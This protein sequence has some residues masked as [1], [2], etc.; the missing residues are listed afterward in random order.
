MHGSANT[1][2][3]GGW[4]KYVSSLAWVSVFAD[5]LD[6]RRPPAD[7]RRTATKPENPVQL[8]TSQDK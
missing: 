2:K 4:F 8:M 6:N 1:I 3:S 5:S 7:Q